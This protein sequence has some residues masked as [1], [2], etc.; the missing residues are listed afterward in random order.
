MAKN[1]YWS[2]S[3]V[4]KCN[5]QKKT[6]RQ[7]KFEGTK[8]VIRSRKSKDR[9]HQKKKDKTINNVLQ[10]ITHKTKDRVTRT[11]LKTECELGR[12]GR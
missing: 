3:K 2:V 4:R 11:A 8:G 10:N 6:K 9:Q 7:E 5:G 12:F 1:R